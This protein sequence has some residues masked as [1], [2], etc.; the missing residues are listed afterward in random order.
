MPSRN[1]ISLSDGSAHGDRKAKMICSLGELKREALDY[2][3]SAA[4]GFVVTEFLRSKK[5]A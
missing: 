3:V 1:A 5:P 2:G 4:I